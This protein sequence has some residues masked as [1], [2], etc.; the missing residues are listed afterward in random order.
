MKKFITSLILFVVFCTVFY[1]AALMLLPSFLKKNMGFA[2]G[3]YGHLYTRIRDIKNAENVDILFLGS[4]HAYRGFD[5]RIFDSAGFRSFNLGSSAQTPVQTQL[6]LDKYLARINPEMVIYEVDPIIFSSDGVESS[7]DLI[8]N[9]TI[10]LATAKMALEM[11]NIKTLNTLIYGLCRQWFNLDNKFKENAVT[12]K[13]SYIKGGFVERKMEYFHPKANPPENSVFLKSQ[14]NYFNKILKYLSEKG[15]K[16]LLVQA[17]VT[18]YF[19]NSRTN[20]YKF[21]SIIKSK[22]LPYYD[23]NQLLRLND[24]LH[25][26]DSHHLNQNGVKI[27]NTKLIQIINTGK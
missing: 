18:S 15:I 6:L 17:P 11:R 14:I 1:I 22:K 27:F 4:S 16:I 5:T 8:A 24:S 26:Y 7:L 23:F 19:Y 21:D 20:N 9:D 12:G 10:T 25:F 2:K 13:D 3:S